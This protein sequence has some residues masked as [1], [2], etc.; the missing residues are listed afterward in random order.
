MLE[1]MLKENGYLVVADRFQNN[2]VK[3]ISDA[4]ENVD[5]LKLKEYDRQIAWCGVMF[6]D[7]HRD[8]FKVRL[9]AD[10]AYWILRKC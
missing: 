4:I 8:I 7:E 10:S 3:C 6:P 5:G 1:S 2:V 9:N